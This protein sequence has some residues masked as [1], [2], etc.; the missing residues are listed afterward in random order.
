[1]PTFFK[2]AKEAYL[3]KKNLCSNSRAPFYEIA[4]KYLPAD[5]DAG[6]ADIGCSMNGGIVKHFNLDEKYE[7]YNLLDGSEEAVEHLQKSGLKASLYKIPDKLPF[8]DKSMGF[9][10]LSHVIEHLPVGDLYELLEELDR[11]IGDKGALVVSTP[12][13]WEKFY[14]NI[15]HIKPY[16]PESIIPYMCE[17][18]NSDR[19]LPQISSAFKIEEIHYRHCAR[20]PDFSGAGSTF[21]LI[22]F[23][24]QAFKKFFYYCGFRNFERNGYTMILRKYIE[25]RK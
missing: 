5:T 13:M 17:S 4:S 6:I 3:E 10:H 18:K 9:V 23:A 1:M 7:N 24:I 8:A 20:K 12:L 19:D 15:G 25:E 21:F 16:P 11:V 2:R 22:D 14:G